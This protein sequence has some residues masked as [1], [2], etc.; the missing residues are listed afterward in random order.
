MRGG[1]SRKGRVTWAFPMSERAWKTI[2]IFT[3]LYYFDFYYD[4]ESTPLQ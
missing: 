3:V 2:D 1:G 4:Y